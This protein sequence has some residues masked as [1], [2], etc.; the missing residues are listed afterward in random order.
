MEG[1]PSS[2]FQGDFQLSGAEDGWLQSMFLVGLLIAS[3]I[4][5]SMAKSK[6]NIRLCGWGLALWSCSVFACGFTW[7]FFSLALCRTLV[8]VGEAALITIVP[9]F[10]DTCAPVDRKTKWLAVFCIAIPSGTALGYAYGGMVTSLLDWRFA[11]FIEAVLMIPLMSFAF[12]VPIVSLDYWPKNKGGASIGGKGG[13][14]KMSGFQ[15][16]LH[17]LGQAMKD[18]KLIASNRVYIIGTIGYSIYSAMMGV[19]AY[20]GPK[21]GQAMFPDVAKYGSADT[22]FGLSTV[23]AGIIGTM[24]GGYM[25]DRAG[26]SIAASLLLCSVMT[27]VGVLVLVICV[28]FSQTVE[29]FIGTITLALILVF[30]IQGPINIVAMWTQPYILRPFACA[31]MTVSIHVFGD[32][33]SA[34]IAGMIH[35]RIYSH[36]NKTK[37]KAES[38]A[39]A[40]KYTLVLM[41]VCGFTA[42]VLWFIGYLCQTFAPQKIK[43]DEDV[44]G[45]SRNAYESLDEDSAD[46]SIDVRTE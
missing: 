46:R 10:I 30:A 33:P 20:W 9:N 28:W 32:V 44:E 21:A 18:V 41:T 2:G 15:Q 23:V 1:L 16:Y 19:F 25:L 36:F 45:N 35:D 27:F 17:V 40:W 4:F 5:A 37:D 26:V 38:D 3:P 6:D 7:N 22:A 39:L 11:F 43:G 12:F 8:G 34:P 29:A 24:L 31:M 42:V 14:N 13:A